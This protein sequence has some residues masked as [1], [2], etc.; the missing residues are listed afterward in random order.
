MDIFHS[1][2]QLGYMLLLLVKGYVDRGFGGFGFL[3]QPRVT[4][5]ERRVYIRCASRRSVVALRHTAVGRKFDLLL[6]SSNT[7]DVFLLISKT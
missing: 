1:P 5:G 4:V 2:D 6:V 3:L 7:P